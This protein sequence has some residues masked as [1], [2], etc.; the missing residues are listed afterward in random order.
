MSEETARIRRLS[1]TIVNQIAAGEVIERPASALKELL[2][3]ALDAGASSVK[4]DYGEGGVKMVSVCDDGRGIPGTDIPLAAE[5]HATSKIETAEDLGRIKSMGFRGEALSSISAVSRLS[6]ASRTAGE[7]H[8]WA[9]EFGTGEASGDPVP[10]PMAPGTEIVARDFFGDVPV[11]RKHLRSAST[12]GGHCRQAFLRISAGN[13]GVEFRLS[14]NGKPKEHHPAE[15]MAV[16]AGRIMGDSFAGQ[17]RAVNVDGGRFALRGMVNV[18][19]HASGGSLA[20]RQF[21][22][23]NCRFVRDKLLMRAVR[24]GIRDI[25]PRGDAEYIL[26]LEMPVEIVDVN[27]HPSKMEVR[28]RSPGE[29]FGFMTRAVREAFQAPLAS[30]P[31]SRTLADGLVAP[32][33]MRRR[34]AP[35]PSR[36][37]Q[38]S[39]QRLFPESGSAFGIETSPA[40][41]GGSGHVPESSPKTSPS[42]SPP[43]PPSSEVEEGDYLG[44]P[45]AL[46]GGIYILSENSKGLVIVDMHA[47]HERIVY[48]RMKSDVDSDEIRSQQLLAP[49]RIDLAPPEMDALRR[50]AETIACTGLQIEPRGESSAEVV[51]VPLSIGENDPALLAIEVLS[52]I[53]Q[54]GVSGA[55]ETM[56][57]AA[58]STMSCHAAVRANRKLTLEDMDAL[59]RQMESTERSGR[60]NHGRPCWHQ[61]GID[62]LDRI[63]L[64]GQ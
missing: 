9:L 42:V 47:A 46:L 27:A 38:P 59:L 15:D 17:S 58:L 35:V 11:R 5:R 48:E 26:F 56:R 23:L 57:N 40:Y 44:L 18:I 50:N 33:L 24:E 55:T 64:R 52:D 28:F 8:G 63:F 49:V 3:N 36:P 25:A 61:I 39:P 43:S 41:P 1:D 53:A 7:D 45:L 16:R 37:Y 51:S 6:I 22:Y 34:Q 19:E 31:S 21:M 54:Y 10:R 12:E 60:C 14:V 32:P 2:E 20:N 30:T 62:Q 29:T 13:P 4:V